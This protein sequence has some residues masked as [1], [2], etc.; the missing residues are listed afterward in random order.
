[1]ASLVKKTLITISI[2]I[3]FLLLTVIAL[4]FLVD[5]DKYRPE[6]LETASRYVNGKLT[7]GKLSLSLWG[8]ILVHSEEFSLYDNENQKVAHVKDV[9]FELPFLSL[10]KGSPKAIFVM[11]SPELQIIRNTSGKINLLSIIKKEKPT[12]VVS[13]K[14]SSKEKP[15]KETSSFIKNASLSI[16]IL[17]AKLL[18][19]D[20]KNKSKTNI[21]DLNFEVK[22]LSFREPIVLQIQANLNFTLK[23]ILSVKGPL[24]VTGEIINSEENFQKCS[25]TLHSDMSKLKIIAKDYFVKN[26]SF[27][28]LINTHI[29]VSPDKVIL[30]K[31]EARFNNAILSARGNFENINTDTISHDLKLESNEIDFSAWTGLFPFLQKYKPNGTILLKAHSKGFFSRPQYD[32]KLSIKNFTFESEYLKVRPQINIGF[33][34]STDKINKALIS[35][36]SPGTSIKISGA[37]NSFLKPKFAFFVKSSGIDLDSLIDFGKKEKVATN[38]K[39]V[40][41]SQNL[42]STQVDRNKKLDSL[43]DNKIVTNAEGTINFDINS[44]NVHDLKLT[45]IKGS[46]K[47]KNL[48]ISITDFNMRIWD[49]KMSSSIKLN[50]M[51]KVPT[52]SFEGILSNLNLNEAVKSKL[53]IL[54][55]TLFGKATFRISGEG[56]SFNTAD[57]IH[58]LSIKGSLNVVNGVFS[59]IDISRI[60]TLAINHSIRKAS[61]KYKELQGKTISEPKSIEGLYERISSNFTVSNG[62]FSA[63]DF[64]AKAVPDKGIDVSGITNI[65]LTNYDISAD[66]IISDTYNI[67]KARDIS[68]K[69]YGVSCL[70]CENNVVKFPVKVRGTLKKPDIS[71]TSVPEALLKNAA[72]NIANA[73]KEKAKAEAKARVN[74]E[75]DN[76]SKKLPKSASDLMKEIKKKLPF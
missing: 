41:S 14:E 16:K 25:I 54:K 40:E 6:I 26:E 4:P 46:I 55:N 70:F 45:D 71:Y 57:I 27:P 18:F 12:E 9:H 8:K 74:K 19:V 10:L 69:E 33:D 38:Q 36:S 73:L 34:F 24:K 20:F 63:P 13:E 1:M 30:N 2:I 37:L 62:R 29:D 61:E 67:T 48:F 52:Y 72:N 28:A 22:N 15:K 5:V 75:I 65:G 42:K 56:K 23:N 53:E 11:N 7:L 49:G 35:F 60:A 39:P 59:T 76:I 47:T 17:N 66:W 50:L 21:D 58:N 51:P 64:L 44:I 68:I 32:G 31:F 43:R 3:V